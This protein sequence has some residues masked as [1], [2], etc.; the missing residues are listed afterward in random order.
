MTFITHLQSWRYLIK[1]VIQ[2]GIFHRGNMHSVDAVVY[3]VVITLDHQQ[4]HTKATV[5]YNTNT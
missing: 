5:Y 1:N 2:P 4:I 3:V